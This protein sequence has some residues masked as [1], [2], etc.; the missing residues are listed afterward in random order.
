MVN[1]VPLQDSKQHVHNSDCWC[2]PKVEWLNDE[3]ELPYENGPLVVH[4][5]A[6]NREA[7][8]KAGKPTGRTWGVFSR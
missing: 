6:D 5:S 4:Q 1:V 3:T 7:I 2:S 8:E